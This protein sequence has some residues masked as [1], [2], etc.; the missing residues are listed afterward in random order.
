MIST[1][2]KID[3][4]PVWLAVIPIIVTALSLSLSVFLLD[5]EPHFAL[6]LGSAT[7][8]ICAYIYGYSWMII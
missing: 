7:A 8:G 2:N 3:L 5:A 4:P 6:I 1:K